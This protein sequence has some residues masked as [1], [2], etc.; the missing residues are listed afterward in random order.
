MIPRAVITVSG[1]PAAEGRC[2]RVVTD[3]AEAQRLRTT[4][5]VVV[6]RELVGALAAVGEVF[7]GSRVVELRVLTPAEET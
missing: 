2:V 7:P 6:G 3:D 1:C 5:A 4:G